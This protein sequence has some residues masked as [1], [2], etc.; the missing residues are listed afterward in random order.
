[1]H[2]NISTNITPVFPKEIKTFQIYRD[3]RS[4]AKFHMW[5]IKDQELI[6]DKLWVC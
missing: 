3:D 5:K 2:I 4:F 6:T 1:M